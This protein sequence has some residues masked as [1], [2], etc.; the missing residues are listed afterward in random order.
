M[1]IE[2]LPA[3]KAE[4]EALGVNDVSAP[5]APPADTKENT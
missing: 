4:A 3:T 5:G 2:N 1:T